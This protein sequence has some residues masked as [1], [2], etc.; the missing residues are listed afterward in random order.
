MHIYFE[1]SKVWAVTGVGNFVVFFGNIYSLINI[2]LKKMNSNPRF[3]MTLNPKE[4]KETK[5]YMCYVDIAPVH[6]SVSIP[7]ENRRIYSYCK[8]LFIVL[9]VWLTIQKLMIK[10]TPRFDPPALLR[11]PGPIRS[12]LLPLGMFE[13]RSHLSRHDAGYVHNLV[14]YLKKSQRPRPKPEDHVRSQS[15]HFWPGRKDY[16]EFIIL[17]KVLLQFLIVS[18]L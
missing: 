18:H 13:T 9:S 1:I 4:Y 2:D 17:V 14:N 3:F 7:K 6:H 12:V 15:H 11:N 16:L 8:T 5:E 10:Q